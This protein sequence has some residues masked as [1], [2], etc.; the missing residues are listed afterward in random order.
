MEDKKWISYDEWKHLKDWERKKV[1]ETLPKWMI[2]F[3]YASTIM[4][5][6]SKFELLELTPPIEE[7]KETYEW[8]IMKQN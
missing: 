3:L 4:D 6:E 8:E 1:I 2:Y 5:I 7:P